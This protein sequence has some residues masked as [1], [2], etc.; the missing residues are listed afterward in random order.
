MIKA[1]RSLVCFHAAAAGTMGPL[2]V[3]GLRFRA[4]GPGRS[5]GRQA[6]DRAQSLASNL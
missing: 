5:R 2:D 3:S 1:G 6:G 4:M